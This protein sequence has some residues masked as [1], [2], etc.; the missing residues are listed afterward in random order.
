MGSPFE[1]DLVCIGSGPAGQ[2]AAVQ[3]AK[4]GRRVAV[5]EQGRCVGGTCLETGTI[6][7]KTF[8]E[9]VRM[10]TG[11]MKYDRGGILKTRP[12][13]EQLVHRVSAVIQ[14]ETEVLEDQLRRNDIH[15][16]FGRARF[17]DPHSLCVESND[18]TRRLRAA[19]ILIA[20]GTQSSEPAGVKSAGRS[21]IT[22]D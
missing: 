10:I 22:S 6:P 11:F 1:Y 17:E 19:H 20:V 15:V 2:R 3:A 14:R 13:M 7:S 12:S 16:I 21:I 9:A 18:E 4:A 5:I 8:R